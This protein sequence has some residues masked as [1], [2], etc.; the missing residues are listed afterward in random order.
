MAS[1]SR[2]AGSLE[3]VSRTRAALERNALD[4]AAAVL[5]RLFAQAPTAALRKVVD[6]ASLAAVT[7]ALSAA[8]AADPRA[9]PLA[10]AR[11]RGVAR[12]DELLAQ[13]GGALSPA[14]VAE[15]TGMSRQSVNNWRRKGQ[16][17][18][19]PR[20]RRDFA[21]PACQFVE[22]RPVP[23][24]D[25]VLAASALRH[26]LSQLEMLLA[27]SPRMEGASPLALLRA[28]RVED[29]VA[30]AA[31]SGSALDDEAPAAPRI[32]RA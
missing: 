7:G 12:R 27:P 10:G 26:P 13:A 17:I 16:L 4:R 25:R 20:G 2:A 22:D 18:A 1:G 14:A 19:L 32:A 5:E 29:A 23:G 3:P 28:G 15:R 24:L 8:V 31:A 21:F 6:E 9:D 11:A 30:V